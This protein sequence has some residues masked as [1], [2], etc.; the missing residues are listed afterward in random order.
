MKG[1]SMDPYEEVRIRN[2]WYNLFDYLDDIQ[3]E[4][5]VMEGQLVE[6]RKLLE[7]KR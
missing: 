5:Y 3:K 1:V 6:I 7:E 2:S 4:I